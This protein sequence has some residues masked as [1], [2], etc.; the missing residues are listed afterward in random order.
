MNRLQIKAELIDIS[1]TCGMKI[2]YYELVNNW[3]NEQ[4]INI[5]QTLKIIL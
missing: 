5:A 4:L 1:D 2:T 3:W